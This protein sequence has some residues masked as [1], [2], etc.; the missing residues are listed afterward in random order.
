MTSLPLPPEGNG[1]LAWVIAA[2]MSSSTAGCTSVATDS[3]RINRFWLPLPRSNFC[4]TGS[5]AP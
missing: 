4:G 1:L 2:A 5:E 3:S